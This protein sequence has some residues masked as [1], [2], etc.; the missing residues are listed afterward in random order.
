MVLGRDW[1]DEEIG[2][3][4]QSAQTSGYEISKFGVSNV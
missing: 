3:L 2:K 1:G 4:C